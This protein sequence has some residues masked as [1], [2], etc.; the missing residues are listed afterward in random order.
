VRMSWAKGM[1]HT[2]WFRAG[3]CRSSMGNVWFETLPSYSASEFWTFM[4]ILR[5]C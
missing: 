4:P 1:Y 3:R 5:K 2:C